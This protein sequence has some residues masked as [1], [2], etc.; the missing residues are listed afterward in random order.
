M[1]KTVLVF[2]L[3]AGGI[4]SLM[5]IITMP[6]HD[7]I[8]WD[9]GEVIGYATMI[10]AFLLIFFGVRSYRENVAGGWV[11]FWRAFSVG[12]MIT[13]VASV[14]YVVTWEVMYFNFVPEFGAKYQAHVID[15]ARADGATPA[16]LEKKVA[17]MQRFA[18]LYQNPL[19]NAAVTFLEPLP[20]GLVFA[21]L[22]AAVLRRRRN[23]DDES[24]IGSAAVVA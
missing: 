3:I 2:G 18:K 12:A 14:C 4:L 10:C 11:S 21:V 19:F 9:R 6:F 7:A 16:E 22:S 1:K 5:M 23:R 17:E 20:V 13:V 15:K 8:G 24:S